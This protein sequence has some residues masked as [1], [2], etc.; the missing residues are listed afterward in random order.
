MLL[1]AGKALLEGAQ[2]QP[3]LAEAALSLPQLH[4][5]P[6]ATLQAELDATSGATIIISGRVIGSLVLQNSGGLHAV[7][8]EVAQPIAL[9]CT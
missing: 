1:G 5:A 3:I 8:S 2:A 6:L 9:V 4:H 7:P